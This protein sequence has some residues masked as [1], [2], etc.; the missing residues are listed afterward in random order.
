MSGVLTRK[1]A[2]LRLR[3]REGR[4]AARNLASR[5]ASTSR[6]RPPGDPLQRNQIAYGLSS[7]GCRFGE[8][9]SSAMRDGLMF[10]DAG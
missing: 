9:R 2:N 7:L 3:V 1:S 10:D 8:A 6:R 5:V 4:R